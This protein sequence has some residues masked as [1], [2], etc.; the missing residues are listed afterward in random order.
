VDL[1]LWDICGAALGH[2]WH[3]LDSF[4]AL[5]EKERKLSDLSISAITKKEAIGN[6]HY[7]SPE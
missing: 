4:Y 6:N 7:F 2:F 5:S 1:V 3:I